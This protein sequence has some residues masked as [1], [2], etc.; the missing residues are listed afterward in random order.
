M[1]MTREEIAQLFPELLTHFVPE[2]AEGINAAIQVDLSGDNGGLY[3]LKIQDKQATI[4]EGKVEKP[5]MTV[6][7]TADDFAALAQGTIDPIQAFM[8]G[9]IKVQGDMGLAL[10]FLMMF[11]VQK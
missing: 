11:G 2:K 8:R 3:W 7:A 1:A 5:K 10:K 6:R 9:R 4:G